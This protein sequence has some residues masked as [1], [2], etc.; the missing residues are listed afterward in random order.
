MI[1][2]YWYRIA[3]W[4][5]LRCSLDYTKTFI[6]CFNLFS[7][8]TTERVIDAKYETNL[9]YVLSAIQSPVNNNYQVALHN[10]IYEDGSEFCPLA[11]Y[12]IDSREAIGALRILNRRVYLDLVARNETTAEWNMYSA[13]FVEE[14]DLP[15]N[16][17][18]F[19]PLPQH[20]CPK[21]VVW[22]PKKNPNI[23]VESLCENGKREAIEFEVDY[24][25]IEQM[26]QINTYRIPSKGKT[27][28]CFSGSLMIIIDYEEKNYLRGR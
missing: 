26:R 15:V 19:S 20:V 24:S 28:L 1:I 3:Q 7:F 2:F 8:N 10:F 11:I 16:L 9:V 13:S 18:K 23:F 25:H 21:L 5:L 12:N 4:N 14:T 22:S 17:T 27:G 6:Q